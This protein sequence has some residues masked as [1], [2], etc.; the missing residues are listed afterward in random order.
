[1][2]GLEAL[3]KNENRWA[4][5][6]GGWFPGER[7][8]FRGFDLHHDLRDMSWM[9]LY[10]FGLT[11]KKFNS[12][13]LKVLNAIWTYTSFPDPRLWNNRVAALAGTAR[14]TPTLAISAA[15]A[16]SEA[17]IYGHRPN[18]KAMNFL[19]RAKQGVG[20]DIDLLSIIKKEL[21]DKRVVAGYGRPI[22]REDERIVHMNKLLVDV[23]M[24]QGEYVLLAKDIE[25]ILLEGRWRFRMN[26]AALA[27][28]ITADMGF[29]VRDFL[30]FTIP[31][32]LA[33][34]PPCY[35]DTK[36]KEEGMFFPFSCARLNYKGVAQRKWNTVNS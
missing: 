11:G 30:I 15:T 3:T 16:V 1:M 4:T 14:S 13:Q 18:I 8:V 26:I 22:Y 31:S 10:V 24:D 32:F 28:A 27:A 34:M 29:S 25:K 2:N 35:L 12:Q 7:V 5:S 33:G 23:G 6:M 19:F 17:T 21:K 20:N 36:E 9:A